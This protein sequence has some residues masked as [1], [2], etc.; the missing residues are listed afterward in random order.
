M[1][2]NLLILRPILVWKYGFEQVGIK[3]T[4]AQVVTDLTGFTNDQ[5]CWR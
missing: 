5:F 4:M 2:F 3:G 1:I